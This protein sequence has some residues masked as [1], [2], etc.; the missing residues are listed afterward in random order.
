MPIYLLF[1][2]G[3]HEA[4]LLFK[5]RSLKMSLNLR[6]YNSSGGATMQCVKC[7]GGAAISPESAALHQLDPR[8]P[9]TATPHTPISALLVVGEFD[10]KKSFLMSNGVQKH[11]FHLV[12]PSPWPLFSSVAA[13]TTTFGG[14]MFMHGFS[15]A[16]FALSFGLTMLV[17][18]GTM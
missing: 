6:A 12:D 18:S 7:C 8:E 14:V 13:F 3:W 5:P 4:H 16:A 1:V 10:T 17:T 9:H 11:P 15:G 2:Y